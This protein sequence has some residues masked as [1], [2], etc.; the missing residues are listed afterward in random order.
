[1]LIVDRKKFRQNDRNCR[2][3]E[4]LSCKLSLKLIKIYS[5]YIL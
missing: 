1:M 2:Q 3:K 5:Q 4:K